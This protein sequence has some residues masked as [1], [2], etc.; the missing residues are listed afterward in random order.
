MQ[1]NK[2]PLGGECGKSVVKT[3]FMWKTPF[4]YGVPAAGQ[5]KH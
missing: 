2:L 3:S 5:R 1:I 4:S